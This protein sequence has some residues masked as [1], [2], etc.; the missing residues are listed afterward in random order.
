MTRATTPPFF[1]PAFEARDIHIEAIDAQEF[2]RRF[3]SGGIVD[4][5]IRELVTRSSSPRATPSSGSGSGSSGQDFFG[6]PW[7]IT[8]AGFGEACSSIRRWLAQADGE[9]EAARRSEL[10]IRNNRRP[11]QFAVTADGVAV[12]ELRGTLLK[13]GSWWSSLPFGTQ[14]ARLAIHNAMSA[15]DVN[16]ILLSIDSPG[17]TVA[18]TADL[19]DAVAAAA[20]TKPVHVHIEDLGASAAYWVASGA[21]RISANRTAMVG[22][23]GTYMAIRDFSALF[24]REGV[25]TH[26]VRAGEAKGIGVLGTEVTPEQLATLQATVDALNEQFLA[27]VEQGRGMKRDQLERIADGRVF[28]GP[29]ALEL[30]LVDGI[31]N[32]EEALSELVVELD[33]SSQSSSRARRAT[34]EPMEDDTMSQTTAAAT[35][36]ATASELETAC[37]GASA[38]FMFS[39]MKVGATVDQ[40]TAAFATV[41]RDEL[42]AKDARIAELEAAAAKA[43]AVTVATET[44]AAAAPTAPTAPNPAPVPDRPGVAVIGTQLAGV[45]PGQASAGTAKDQFE[46]LVAAKITAG[47]PRWKAV[48]DCS[49]EAPDLHRAYIDEHSV[50]HGRGALPEQRRHPSVTAAITAQGAGV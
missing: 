5:K 25:K 10:E 8:E 3:A 42:A 46:A 24:E 50:A 21:T 43:P 29:E 48:M 22:S 34:A 23:I 28:V 49:A 11:G 19:A 4:S 14:G 6:A 35:S 33:G 38:D 27:A 7:A 26:V 1:L 13:Y 40:A 12:I 15:G 2:E 36:A 41:Q 9:P 32:I 47:A 39:Q 44:P 17:G 37:P 30:G 20:A 16:G 45:G 31:Q 18:G